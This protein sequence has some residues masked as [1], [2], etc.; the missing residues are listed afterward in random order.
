MGLIPLKVGMNHDDPVGYV[1]RGSQEE[2]IAS[3]KTT[4]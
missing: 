4:S 3:I 1:L 2:K